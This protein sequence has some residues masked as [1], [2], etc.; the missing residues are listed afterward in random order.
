METVC[1]P[2]PEY[3]VQDDKAWLKELNEFV[4]VS[5]FVIWT[6]FS[7]LF[8]GEQVEQTDGRTGA[9]ERQ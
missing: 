6:H 9:A 3:A 5:Y 2:K 1:G 8:I 4:N 7:F